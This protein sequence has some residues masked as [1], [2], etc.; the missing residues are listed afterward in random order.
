MDSV[1]KAIIIRYGAIGDQII[2]TPILGL[3][4]ADGYR[5]VFNTTETGKIVTMHNPH[6]DEYLMHDSS[7]PPTDELTRHWN[8]ITKG[9]DK[10]INLSESIEGS[11]AKVKWHDDFF[12]SKERRHL[13][14][15]KNF[16]DHTLELA[17]YPKVKGKNGELYFSPLEEKWA[18][19]YREK[20]GNRFLILWALSG[21]SIH[22]AYPFAEYVAIKFL[23]EHRDSMIITCGDSLCQLIEW[24]HPRSKK[25]SGTMP[26]RNVLI[27][28]KYVDLVVGT[29]T[30]ILHAAGCFPTPKII[31]HSSNTKENVSKYWEN[32]FD[33]SADV[34]CQPCHRLHYSMEHCVADAK[35]GSPLCMAQIKPELLYANLEAVYRKWKEDREWPI[36]SASA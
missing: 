7:I 31:M 21:S 6:I 14:C 13:K 18:K 24:D 29:D 11:L 36:L 33:I 5:T 3:L 23:Q 28:T 27:M 20:Q 2:L 12:W 16:Y 17:G 35:L 15:N 10:V 26:L 4:K 19:K 34:H 30:G 25:W 32:C 1:K 8:K 9:Y 22:K